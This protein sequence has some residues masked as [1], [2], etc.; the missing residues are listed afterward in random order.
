MKFFKPTYLFIA[1]VAI[2]LLSFFL[3]VLQV[4]LGVKLAGWEVTALHFSELAFIDAIPA[5]F[6]FLFTALVNFW[7]VGLI[8]GYF[9]E[10]N[11]LKLFSL[12]A[13]AIT[14]SFSWL[15]LFE[16]SSVL[17]WG[18]YTWLI[19]IILIISGRVLKR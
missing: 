2:Y 8:V 3:P 19:G 16:H 18:Y 4:S 9:F 15:F 7:V 13:L 6:G 14:S 11:N 5:Y 10:R 12:A 1:G 17:L